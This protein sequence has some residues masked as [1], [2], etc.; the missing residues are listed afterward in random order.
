MINKLITIALLTIVVTA[1]LPLN[2]VKSYMNTMSNMEKVRHNDDLLNA[3]WM[4]ES[5]QRIASPRGQAG[6]IGPYQISKNY[7]IDSKI[8][9]TWEMCEDKKYSERVIVSYMNRYCKEAWDTGNAEVVAR[10]HNGG[11]R[12]SLRTSTLKYWNKVKTVLLK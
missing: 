4:I 3:I 6:E 7:W 2:K 5:S 8:E 11:P 1:F 10:I 12:G 9:G